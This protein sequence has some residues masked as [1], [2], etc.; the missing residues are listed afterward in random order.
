ML[1]QQYRWMPTAVNR[2]RRRRCLD[3]C[4][5]RVISGQPSVTDMSYDCSIELIHSARPAVLGLHQAAALGE[6][7]EPGRLDRD[8]ISRAA[9]LRAVGLEYAVIGATTPAIIPDCSLRR[10]Y[11]QPNSAHQNSAS[12]TA[13]CES[14]V[15]LEYGWRKGRKK[16]G[17]AILSAGPRLADS[18]TSARL[19]E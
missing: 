19:H 1:S 9:S 12:L 11:W 3:D 5:S 17:L 14:A 4:T 10:T 7:T 8:A 18:D 6:R 13:C 2:C 15:L 16:R